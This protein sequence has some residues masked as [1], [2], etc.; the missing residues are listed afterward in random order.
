MSK[1]H[2]NFIEAWNL[3]YKTVFEYHDN[4]I[5]KLNEQQRVVYL[6]GISELEFKIY[7]VL[8]INGVVNPDLVLHEGFPEAWEFFR[9]KLKPIN[10]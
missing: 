1:T 7:G 4:E 2:F 8:M 10:V 5:N 9:N 3:F 6:E